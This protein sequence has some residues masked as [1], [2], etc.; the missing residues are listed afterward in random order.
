MSGSPGVRFLQKQGRELFVF[1][2]QLL[3][4]VFHFKSGMDKRGS[5]WDVGRLQ[6]YGRLPESVEFERLSDILENY[7]AAVW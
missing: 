3:D 6:S 7:K 4:V 2:H 1:A 5:P